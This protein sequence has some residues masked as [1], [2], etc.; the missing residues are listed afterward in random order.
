[1]FKTWCKNKEKMFTYKKLIV[2]ILA[3]F[4]G[5]PSISLG[6]SFVAS[7][8]QG[9]TPAEAVQIIAEQ[10]DSLFG[11]VQ[12]L[13]TKQIETAQ[14]IEQT[15]LEIERLKLENENLRLKNENLNKETE[16]VSAQVVENEKAIDIVNR[17]EVIEK[18]RICAKNSIEIANKQINSP[19][20]FITATFDEVTRVIDKISYL[21]G[22]WYSKTQTDEICWKFSYGDEGDRC[23]TR[24]TYINSFNQDQ[25]ERKRQAMLSIERGQEILKSTQAEFDELQCDVYLQKYMPNRK[26]PGCA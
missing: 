23:K 24:E 25:A 9:K 22:T 18:P 26:E 5:I 13:E 21:N 19:D 12:V 4:L 15:N 6:G 16:R 7:L 14:N 11:R 8:I 10:M 1:M 2:L 20:L 17:C 3:I